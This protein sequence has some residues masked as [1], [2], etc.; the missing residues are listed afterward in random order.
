MFAGLGALGS[1][2]VSEG[3][4]GLTDCAAASGVGGSADSSPPQPTAATTTMAEIAAN[5]RN[6]DLETV[7]AA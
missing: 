6:I 1:L 3:V 2:A 4:A 5:T 7:N